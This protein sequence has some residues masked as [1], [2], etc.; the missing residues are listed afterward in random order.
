M[1]LTAAAVALFSETRAQTPPQTPAQRQ[2]AAMQAAP[3]ATIPAQQSA[4]PLGALPAT[5][6]PI[7]QRPGLNVVVLD[8][9]HGGT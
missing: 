4:P 9:A 6:Q 8:P 7:P 2:L 3:P 1:C 5:P